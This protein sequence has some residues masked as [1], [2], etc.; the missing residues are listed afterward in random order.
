MSKT[1]KKTRPAGF[2]YWTRR[3]GNCGGSPPGRIT[4]NRTHKVERRLARR[5]EY[6]ASMEQIDA[7]EVISPFRQI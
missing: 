3:P 1:I 5:V 2:D 7:M 4:K 6:L